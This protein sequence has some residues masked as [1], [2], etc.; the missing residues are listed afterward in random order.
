MAE[1][2]I[3]ADVRDSD[4]PCGKIS[5]LI[6]EPGTQVVT[7]LAVEPKHRGRGRLVPVDLVDAAAGEITLRC[8]RPEFE[9]LDPAEVTELLPA[10]SGDQVYNPDLVGGVRIGH[11]MQANLRLFDGAQAT[12]QGTVPMGEVEV[13]RGTPV[14]ATDGVI[15]QIQGLVIDPG[16]HR[17]SHIV[18]K[19]GHLWG[20]KEVAIPISAVTQATD[21]IRLTISKQDVPDLPPVDIHHQAP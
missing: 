17:V 4:G 6:V 19:E 10:G 11:L 1:F 3:G 12:T 8:T 2:V 20:Q 13:D 21:V 5:R 15:G 14:C 7:H 18:L 9:K 16:S